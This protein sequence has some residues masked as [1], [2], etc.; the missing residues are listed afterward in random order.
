MIRYGTER[1]NLQI[2]YPTENTQINKNAEKQ[3][4]QTTHK[5]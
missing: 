2:P 5:A 3:T 4:E 1:Y